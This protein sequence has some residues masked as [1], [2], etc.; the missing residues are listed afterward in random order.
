VIAGIGGIGK[1]T[2]AKKIF[3]SRRS[4]FS[5]ASYLCNFRDKVDLTSFQRQLLREL[6]GLEKKITN[7]HTGKTMLRNRLKG[8]K[9]LIILDGVDNREKIKSVLDMNAVGDGSLIFITCRDKDILGGFSANTLLYEVKPLK[10][11]NA[12]KLFCL[13]AFGQSN[14]PEEYEDLVEEFLKICG[15]LPLCLKVF[16]E[17]LSGKLDGSYW[18]RQLELF[19]QGLP[20][21]EADTVINTL[22]W[23]YK[24]MEIEQQEM[25]LDVGCFFVG[26][27]LELSVRVL[28]GLGY[29]SDVRNCLESLRQKY[30]LD[31]NNDVESQ[32][33]IGNQGQVIAISEGRHLILP[34]VLQQRSSKIIMQNQ[35][36][37]FV[38]RIVR[39]DLRALDKQLRLSWSV[40]IQ[41]M[42]DL[43][44]C[45]VLEF[46]YPC[47]Q[48]TILTFRVGIFLLIESL[49]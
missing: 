32:N 6:L 33:E 9:V 14:P 25:L 31:I 5:R 37:E 17:Q 40:E 24:A 28:E 22:K 19:S 39:E 45:T 44:V 11:N 4:N 29:L 42:L 2:L 13:H 34:A 41:K 15:G 43:Q 20:L 26:E 30:F 46:S 16:G 7:S 23:S 18:K 47:H 49:V 36:R 10:R 12:L 21:T 38:R 27:D 3:N 48:T 35:V 1:S 8:L